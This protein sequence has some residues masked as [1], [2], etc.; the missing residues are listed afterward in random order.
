MKYPPFWWLFGSAALPGIERLW[1][2][3]W[4]GLGSGERCQHWVSYVE[5]DSFPSFG[6]AR[7]CGPGM[8]AFGMLGIS[9]NKV[10]EG[11]LGIG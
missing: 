10:L 9:L 5:E 11:K 1:G 8:L 3:C 6:V 7:Q 4:V 2:T